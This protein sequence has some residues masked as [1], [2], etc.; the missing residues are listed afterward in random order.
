MNR[1]TFW[2]RLLDQVVAEVISACTLRV[3]LI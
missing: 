3:Y 1:A 2:S